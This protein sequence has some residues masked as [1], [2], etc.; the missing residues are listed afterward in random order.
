VID[1]LLRAEYSRPVRVIAFNTDEGYARDVHFMT[2]ATQTKTPAPCD[3]GVLPRATWIPKVVSG[4]AGP[5]VLLRM[6]QLC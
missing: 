6:D 5:R 4:C 3:A 1:N 2:R